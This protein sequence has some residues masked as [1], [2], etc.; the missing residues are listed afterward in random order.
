MQKNSSSSYQ[1]FYNN[2][3]IPMLSP[4]ES[5]VARAFLSRKPVKFLKD[6][7]FHG[8]Q[9][10]DMGCGEGR[11]ALFL[12]SLG[13][14]VSATEVSSDHVKKISKL[15]PGIEFMEGVSTSLPF[16]DKRFDS[17][18]CA[19]SMYYLEHNQSIGDVLNELNRL[20][21]HDG[22]LVGTFINEDHFA[23]NN[24]HKLPDKSAI[25]T[26]DPLAFRNGIRI[27]PLWHDENLSEIMKLFNFSLFKSSHLVDNCDGYKRSLTYF[28]AYK[29]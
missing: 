16:E 19:N 5:F 28:S 23:L 29:V 22:L 9:I 7:F 11:H 24:C 14:K 15:F 25:L 4:P 12:K 13:F 8:K 27:R 20:L 2:E 3:N 21:K 10:L 1:E 17:I 26:S 6:Y 18:L